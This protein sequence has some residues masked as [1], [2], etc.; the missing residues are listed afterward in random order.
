MNKKQLRAL[1]I[2][3]LDDGDGINAKAYGLLCEALRYEGGCQD[4]ISCVESQ[5]NRSFLPE[6]HEL[7][8]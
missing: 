8:A 5:T 3:L 4:I 1:A 2:A 6:D 7:V